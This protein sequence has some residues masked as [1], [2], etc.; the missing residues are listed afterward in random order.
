MRMFLVLSILAVLSL[1]AFVSRPATA[2]DQILAGFS[3]NEIRFDESMGDKKPIP[4]IPKGWRFVGVSNGEKS[5]S[6]NLWFQDQAGNIYLVQG[7][8]SGSEFIL[9]SPIGKINV[10]K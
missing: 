4:I 10:S 9:L 8:T 7:F 2:T 3:V 6:N 1:A 5:N